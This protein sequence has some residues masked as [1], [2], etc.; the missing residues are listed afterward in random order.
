MTGS[1]PSSINSTLYV[2]CDSGS[3]ISTVF[4]SK[5]KLI[6]FIEYIIE[7]NQSVGLPYIFIED[8]LD[9]VYNDDYTYTEDPVWVN[10]IELNNPLLLL[11]TIYA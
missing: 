2:Y 10:K 8:A 11:E 3:M 1:L 5:N 7:L 4:D 9:K 6:Q